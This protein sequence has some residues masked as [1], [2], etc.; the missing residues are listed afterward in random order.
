MK[1]RF[2][3]YKHFTPGLVAPPENGKTFFPET[4][5]PDFGTT[6]ILPP[7]W[8]HPLKTAKPFSRKQE[9]PI[10]GLSQMITK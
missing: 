8:L 1:P 6:N 4:R 10:L 9:T 7:G 3:D 5:N 2:W